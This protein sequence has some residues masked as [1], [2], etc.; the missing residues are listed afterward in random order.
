[1]PPQ[2][3]TAPSP[4]ASELQP[5]GC[6]AREVSGAREDGV[7]RQPPVD[8]Y[9]PLQREAGCRRALEPPLPPNQNAQAAGNTMALGERGSFSPRLRT[10]AVQRA[11]PPPRPHSPVEALPAPNLIAPCIGRR[12][13]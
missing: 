12:C 13:R 5:S 6:H 1:M 7:P 3:R 4:E 9:L 10:H 2:L 11:A 8:E